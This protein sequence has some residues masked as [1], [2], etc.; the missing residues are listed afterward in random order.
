MKKTILFD[1][2]GTNLILKKV[3]LKALNLHWNIS[4]YTVPDEETLQL[5][6]GPPLVDAFQ[7]Y[8]GMTFEQSEEN[9]L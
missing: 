5:F 6:L 4:V 7:E 8:C 2:D 3:F 9:I 1:L